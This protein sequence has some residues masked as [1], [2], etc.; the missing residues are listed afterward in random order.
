MALYVSAGR[1]FRRTVVI[2]VVA[3]LIAL[4]V[5]WAIGRQ[6]APA[7]TDRVAAVQHQAEQEATGLERLGIEYEQVLGGTDDLDDSVVQPLDAV[8]E[9]LQATMNRAAWLTGAERAA[10]LDAVSQVRQ[11][12]IDEVP[13]EEFTA[14][15]VAA[16][17][18]VRQELGAEST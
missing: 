9:D 12:A 6:Q 5:G 17:A 11:A 1:R 13:L 3:S 14:A 10:L 4:V 7:I 2:A 15:T 8:R 16:A 18:L